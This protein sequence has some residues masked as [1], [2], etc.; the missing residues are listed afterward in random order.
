MGVALEAAREA[1][2]GQAS[3]LVQQV[4]ENGQ[5]FLRERR[6]VLAHELANVSSAIRRAA[7]KLHDSDSEFIAYYVDTAA[8]RVEE[9]G[10]YIDEHG[11][12]EVAA[13]VSELA[14]RQ[15]LLFMG[16][17]FAAGVAVARF[18]KAANDSGGRRR[19][20]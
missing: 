19:G 6:G 2:G 4:K 1:I 15:P 3:E 16:G 9:I 10:Q 14:R 8:N 17:M 7:D 20:R 18:I 13:D 12:R 5:E 11:L